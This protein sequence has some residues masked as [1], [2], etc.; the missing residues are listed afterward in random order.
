[1]NEMNRRAIAC[2]D[3]ALADVGL[4]DDSALRQVLHE[5]FAWATTTT[6]FRYHRSLM[7]C[8]AVS[9]SHTGH[10]MGLQAQSTTADPLCTEL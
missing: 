7:M 5:Y 3:Q 4:V 10:W 6:M 2:F 9:I 8:M 1:M